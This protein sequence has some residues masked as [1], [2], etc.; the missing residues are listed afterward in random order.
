MGLWRAKWESRAPRAQAHSNGNGPIL[1]PAWGDSL[2]TKSLAFIGPATITILEFD[3]TTISISEF[4]LLQ[5][6][7][8]PYK[9]VSLQPFHIRSF[10]CSHTQWSSSV[11]C[12]NHFFF[13]FC[14]DHNL[15]TVVI[16]FLQP[17]IAVLLY[18]D[19][20]LCCILITVL[21]YCNIRI[22]LHLDCSQL[23]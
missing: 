15:A 22:P 4:R 11:I 19:T 8:V 7:S 13:F 2:F 17:L 14:Y 12:Y 5:S 18:C 9:I 1:H 6:S 20:E 23:I 16:A 10:H 3:P 21:L